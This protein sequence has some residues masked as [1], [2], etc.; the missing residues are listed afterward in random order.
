MHWLASSEVIDKYY[1][2]PNSQR[3]K[4]VTITEVKQCFGSYV[5][6]NKTIIHLCNS[7]FFFFTSWPGKYS[8]V[9]SENDYLIYCDW[10]FGTS[11]LA[12]HPNH[13]LSRPHVH[14]NL[15]WSLHYLQ[16]NNFKILMT[17]YARSWTLDDKN[18]SNCL[19]KEPFYTSCCQT[20]TGFGV[21]TGK[22]LLFIIAFKLYQSCSSL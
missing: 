5:V 19:C 3:Y 17:P 22:S 8:L 15:F 2:P 13:T 10:L 9:I 7:G 12:I 14:E 6:N 4:I 1:S 21:N 20:S 11:C 18:C 16:V